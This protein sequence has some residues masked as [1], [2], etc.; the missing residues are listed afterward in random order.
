MPL[1]SLV[2]GT[3]KRV[4][5]V[6][7]ATGRVLSHFKRRGAEFVAGV[8]IFPGV[9]EEA[10]R[11]ADVD[12]VVTGDIESEELPWPEQ[13]FDLVIASF[14]LEHVSDPWAVLRKL[15]KLTAPGGQLIGALPNVRHVS[16]LLPLLCT[17]KWKYEDQ[18]IMDWTHLRF[19][20]RST[21]CELLESSGFE[22]R[23]VVPQITAVKYK[24]ANLLTASLLRDFFGFAYNFSAAADDER[25]VNRV[26]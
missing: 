15:R 10:R 18:G 6:G 26:A 11:N 21:I 8:E 25:T 12:E 14:V 3:P 13:S 17:G 23:Q 22:P 4:L 16:V 7:C 24:V 20:T 5:D 19:F 2:S 9:A 1:V